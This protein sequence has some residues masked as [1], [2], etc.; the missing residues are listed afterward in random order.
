MTHSWPEMKKKPAHTGAGL[1][2]GEQYFE[3]RDR[4]QA[5]KGYAQCMMMKQ[6]DAEK[7]EREEDEI[8]RHPQDRN[9]SFRDGG[10]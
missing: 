5:R 9:R 7:S 1:E 6:R 3:E 8:N 2:T 4:C 10:D